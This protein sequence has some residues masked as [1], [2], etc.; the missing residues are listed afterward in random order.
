MFR[1]PNSTPMDASPREASLADQREPVPLFVARLRSTLWLI[2]GSLVLLSLRDVWL[3][4][5]PILPAYLVR[6]A[7]A[8]LVLGLL[9]ALRLDPWGKRTVTLALITGMAVCIEV[10]AVVRSVTTSGRRRCS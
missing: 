8:L 7:H 5:V 3:D 10:A 6:F 4:P 9:Q 2:L 1:T